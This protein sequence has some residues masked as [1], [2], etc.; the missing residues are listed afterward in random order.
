MLLQKYYGEWRDLHQTDLIRSVIKY[1]KVQ[2]I[3]NLK[4]Q[5]WVESL[6]TTWRN[7]SLLYHCMQDIHNYSY[8]VY[9][10]KQTRRIE[11]VYPHKS[12]IGYHHS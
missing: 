7:D 12:L 11:G 9:L 3:S 10:T 4:L 6:K 2:S 8:T 1:T 5:E